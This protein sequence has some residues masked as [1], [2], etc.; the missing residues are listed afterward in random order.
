MSSQF[1]ALQN[2]PVFCALGIVSEH[3][4]QWI[5]DLAIYSQL[6][7]CISFSTLESGNLLNSTR[8]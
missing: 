4:T 1:S 3:L 5:D 2:C 6:V 7:L 8:V